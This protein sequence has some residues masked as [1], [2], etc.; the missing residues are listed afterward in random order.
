MTKLLVDKNLQ[1]IW[2]MEK[3][4]LQVSSLQLHE[5]LYI[6]IKKLDK[7]FSLKFDVL[8]VNNCI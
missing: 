3:L 6:Q 2:S 1:F 7:N 4:D 5:D 8:N